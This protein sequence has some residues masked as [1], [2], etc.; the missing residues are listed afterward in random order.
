MD[1]ILFVVV[2]TALIA[3]VYN[4]CLKKLD[5][6]PVIGYIAAGVT[7]AL[8]FSVN[9]GSEALDEIGEFG[10]VFLM[11]TIGLEFSLAYLRAMR[12]E[13]F[14]FG[15][16][17]VTITSVLF[18]AIGFFAFGIELKIAVIIGSA[19]SMSSTAIVL[20]ILKDN[21]SISKPFGRQVLGILIFQDIAVIP[22]L[23]MVTLFSPQPDGMMDPMRLIVKMS[24]S[25]VIVLVLLSTVG[26]YAMTQLLKYASNSQTH[27]I[28]VGTVLLVVVAAA[29]LAH[30]F[31][32]SYSLGAL[33]AGIMIAETR[34]K[35]QVEADLAPFRDL[36]L[37]VFFVTVGLQINL[38]LFIDNVVFILLFVVG[39]MI[40]KGLI[41]YAISRALSDKKSAIR[42]AVSLM[43]MGEFSFA[44]FALS[45]AMM[46]QNDLL[47]MITVAVA[48]SMVLT[49][50]MLKKMENIASLFEKK[51]GGAAAAAIAF[52]SAKVKDHVIVVGYGEAL[53]Q[54]AAQMLK[55][56]DVPYVCIEGQY[57][58]VEDGI[59]R[60]HAVMLGNATQLSIL[61]GAG[62][63]SAR[64][65]IVAIDREHEIRLIVDNALEANP[66]INIVLKTNNR[67][68]NELF[69][70][71]PN[72]S[73]VDEYHEA[74]RLMIEYALNAR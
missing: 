31:G 47:G 13:V 36:L 30:E 37:G 11:F 42:S 43:Q 7:A 28:F 24:V 25:A 59:D 34:Y 73:M 65:I 9:K 6:P 55:E 1:H 52:D 15:I 49:P 57:N 5:I 51:R 41:V 27:E 20:K 60:G 58:R 62:L 53:G 16:M 74:A 46:P 61:E 35:H 12:R 22:I 50:F 14:L 19:L 64:A 23:L 63:K 29:L 10:I 17:Q 66:D 44:I 69:F 70:D 38:R 26:K 18:C 4:L 3:V 21:G 56:Q 45:S 40:L 67:A 2:I 68:Q 72:I 48:I 71:A 54:Q 33:I 32:F 39:V 8:I